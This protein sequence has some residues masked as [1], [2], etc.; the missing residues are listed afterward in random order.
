MAMQ[1]LQAGEM[2]SLKKVVIEL[3]NSRHGSVQTDVQYVYIHR[4]LMAMAENKKLITATDLEKFDQSYEKFL[5][6][7]GG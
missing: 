3:R 7:R 1:V 4:T 6:S 5:K 2:L